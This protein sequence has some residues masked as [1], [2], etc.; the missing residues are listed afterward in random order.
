MTGSH[1]TGKAF[2]HVVQLTVTLLALSKASPGPS[3]TLHT[4]VHA[5][6]ERTAKLHKEN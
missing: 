1:L 2:I 6:D 3:V 4:H 5:R